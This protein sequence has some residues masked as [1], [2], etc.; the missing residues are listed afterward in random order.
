MVLRRALPLLA[1][2][3]CILMEPLSPVSGTETHE[4]LRADAAYGEAIAEKTPVSK[5]SR[6]RDDVEVPLADGTL[7]EEDITGSLIVFDAYGFLVFGLRVLFSLRI[8][9]RKFRR[10]CVVYEFCH[11]LVRT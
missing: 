11:V 1:L 9:S 10:M 4:N 3:V 6:L 8:I 5:T 2:H 7:L